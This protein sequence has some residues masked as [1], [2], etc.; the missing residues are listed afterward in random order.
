MNEMIFSDGNWQ[1]TNK[2]NISARR[3]LMSNISAR[4]ALIKHFR[5]E[6]FNAQAKVS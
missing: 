3:A 5:Q 4:R 1:A 2:S 6:S